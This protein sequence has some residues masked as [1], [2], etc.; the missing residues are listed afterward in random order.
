MP[1][2]VTTRYSLL[3]LS[4]PL[5]LWDSAPSVYEAFFVYVL[6]LNQSKQYPT[7]SSVAAVVVPL[8]T[9]GEVPLL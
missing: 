7:T 3:E 4:P 2:E 6:L 8:V 5:A 1:V 9:V